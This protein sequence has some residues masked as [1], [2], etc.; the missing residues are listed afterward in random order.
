MTDGAALRDWIKS[1]GFTLKYV[2]GCLGITPQG[3]WKKLDGETEFK[4]SEI[5]TFVSIL[6]MSTQ[7]RDAIFFKQM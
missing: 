2:S 7:A 1:R 6:G 5:A 3:L 4:A